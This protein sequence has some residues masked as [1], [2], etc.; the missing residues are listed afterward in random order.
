MPV[1]IHGD[2]AFIGQGVI[3]ETLNL[4]KTPGYQTGGTVH[5]V[6]NNQIGF[7]TSL[8]QEARST[9]Y[10]TEMAKLIEAPIFH[11]N[12]N[13]PDAVVFIARLAIE[14]RKTFNSDV[15]IDLVCYRR[16]GHNEADEPMVTQ[17][18][19][20][21]RIQEIETTREIYACRLRHAGIIQQGE[22]EK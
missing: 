19:M 2:A 4:A 10:C 3:A 16:H 1:L 5:I 11:V 17:P 13:D 20:Y 12:A 6:V 21:H 18:G 15:V 22:D 14:Y 7:T 8:P 9:R